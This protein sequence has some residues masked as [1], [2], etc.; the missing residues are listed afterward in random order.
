MIISQGGS[1]S[2]LSDSIQARLRGLAD[3]FAA[4]LPVRMQEVADS[5]RQALREDASLDDACA[6]RHLVHKL[7][8]SAA[9][10]GFHH[11][12]AC[13][14]RLE[15]A[16]DE[17]VEEER[18][19]RD[20]DRHS[21]RML[22]SELSEAARFRSPDA[23]PLEELEEVD[24]NGDPVP[25]GSENRQ[26]Y[27]PPASA[28]RS[29]DDRRLVIV[30]TRNA[31]LSQSLVERFSFYGFETISLVDP[32]ELSG[33]I[34]PGCFTA[35]VLDVAYI[36]NDPAV[37][38]D[39]L[40]IVE[41][42]EGRI[43][44]VYVSDRDDFSV[45]LLAVR[46]AGDAF[47]SS[48][49]DTSRV[50]D[51]VDGLTS[52]GGGEPYHVLIVD[53]DAEQVSY[54]ALVLQRAGMIT[55]VVSDPEYMF[56]VL[57]ES[58]P[59]LI[60]MDMYM[61]G[62]SGP[63]LATMIRQQEAFVGVPIV[64][65]SVETDEDK[66][67]EAVSRGG[68][69]FLCKPIRPQHLVTAVSNRVERTRSMRFFM[70]RD[71]LTGLLNHTHLMQSLSTE[72][73]RAERVGRPL[74]FAMIDIDHF[75]TVNDSYGHLTGD[76]VLKSL[77]RLLFDRLRKT[78]VIGRYGGEEFGIVMF[79]VDVANATRILN[80]IREDFSTMQHETGERRFAVTFSGGIASFPTYDGP[81]PIS[82]AADKALYAAKEKGRNR[83]VTF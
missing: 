43:H 65:L 28:S 83:I 68:D 49:V 64:F 12:T 24:A 69:G 19:P 21:I 8:G 18:S 29:A 78:D 15:H 14:K 56:A 39:V 53:D 58:K 45:R 66:Q 42:G 60:L 57:I 31:E 9:T 2:G 50:I 81:G 74:C 5:A 46:T 47:F 48:P 23:A 80:S 34:G 3:A 72:V 62:C 17:L 82:E 32:S 22:V 63:E 16:L 73:Q 30:L 55:S 59:D 33:P 71:S 67:F 27:M 75:K 61:P 38:E 79:N 11:V 7:A 41:T 1:V 26:E 37:A 36:E 52:G 13:A 40:S 44:I 77:S 4:E 76:R 54:H 35:V 10:F 6:L 20:G 70:E 51:T 25:E